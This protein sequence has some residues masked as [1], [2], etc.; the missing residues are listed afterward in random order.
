[1]DSDFGEN[2][3][4]N[5]KALVASVRE[6]YRVFAPYRSS[7][8]PIGCPCCVKAG[9]VNVLFSRPLERLSADDL[10]RFSRKVLTTWGDVR[11][12]KHFLPRM[13]ELPVEDFAAPV[14]C[15]GIFLK[16]ALAN[17]REWPA[18]E[19][20]AVDGYIQ[21]IW[22]RCI[23]DEACVFHLDGW[24]CSFGI[25]RSELEPFLRDWEQCRWSPGYEKMRSFIDDNTVA[26]IR[27]RTLSGG[28]WNADSATQIAEWLLSDGLT[29][30]LNS[31]FDQSLS[32]A[33]GY[34]DELALLLDRLAILR[35]SVQ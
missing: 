28:F 23:T 15:D 27:K 6:L 34:V 2:V 29:E 12:F 3:D 21:A 8:H 19:R 33:A 4:I 35:R 13:L 17:W 32:S 11:D 1:M 24:L 10:W 26:L 5:R 16:L 14:D 22:R 31:V 7:G 9:D 18:V 20:G 30:R 25:A